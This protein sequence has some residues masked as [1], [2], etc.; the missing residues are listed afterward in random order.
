MIS[1]PYLCVSE[2]EK[3]LSKE[4]ERTGGQFVQ[5]TTVG[6]HQGLTEVAS[7]GGHKIRQQH[8]TMESVALL[9][10]VPRLLSKVGKPENGIV[11]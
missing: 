7:G 6:N 4:N 1:K 2:G 5:V 8:F 10:L 11:I 3:D 9:A